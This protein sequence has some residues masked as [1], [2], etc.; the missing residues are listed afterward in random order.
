MAETVVAAPPDGSDVGEVIRW[1]RQREGLT[2]QDAA[3]LLN[4]TQSRLSKLEKGSQALRDVVELRHIASKLGIPPERLGVLPDRSGDA[5]PRAET[6]SLDPGPARDGQERWRAVRA[7]LNANR[8]RLGDLAADL[9]PQ[10]RRIPGTS[11]LTAAGWV[12]DEPVDLAAVELLWLPESPPPEITG[13]APEAA[14]SRAVLPS[15]KPYDR[16]SRALRDLAR[17]TL[18]D[19]RVSYRLLSAEWA[20]GRGSFG[21]NYTSYFDVLD[22]GEAVGHEFAS[23]W[24]DAGRR[25]PSMADLPF[26]RLIEDPFDLSARPILPSINTLT[27]R[28]DPIEGHRMYLHRRNA[29]AVAAAGGMYHVV[30]AGVFQPAAL[31][32]AHQSN[33]FSFWRNIQREYSEEFL[34]NAE[35]DGNSVD[36]IEYLAEEPFASFERARVA[37]DFRVSALA[38]VVE[39]LTLW[40]E[41][42]TVAVIEA[43]VFDSLFG[44]MVAVNDEGAAV[45]TDAS[46][47]TV[48]I[49]FTS[50]ARE[51]LRH[52]PLSPISRACIELVWR[53]R[54]TLLGR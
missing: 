31:A 22:I 37:G 2:Q 36:P 7:E 29:G 18:F 23:G 38:L 35:H 45:S 41:L 12:P 42:L 46:R 25:R 28:R 52:E 8:A 9:Y 10:E 27:I 50:A 39:P 17:P 4:T 40:V 24:L 30:P 21:F 33:D 14:G 48:G 11:V 16:Y 15:G 51:K 47:P 26:R 6:V 20:D 13:K 54:G 44:D 34:G 1:Y 3:A 5:T 53:H 49:P 43:P 32:P 19:N